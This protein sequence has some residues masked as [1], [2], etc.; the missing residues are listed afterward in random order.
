MRATGGL[1]RFFREYVL[2][3]WKWLAGG[4]LAMAVTNLITLQLPALAKEIV[5]LAV[6]G[7]S[8]SVTGPVEMILLLGG[9]LVFVRFLSRAMFFWPGRK[10]EAAVRSDWFSKVLRLQRSW[11]QKF[12][13]GDL[14]SRLS[15]DTEYLRVLFAFGGMALTNM[16]FLSI[17][18]IYRMQKIDP[19][20][21]LL[22]LTPF[23][24]SVIYFR[25]V[26]PWMHRISKHSQKSL[27]MLTSRVSELFAGLPAVRMAVAEESFLKRTAAVNRR[28][29]RANIRLL[30]L[31][32][33][34][35]PMI[36]FL[37]GLSQVVVL[38]YGG[39]LLVDKQISAGDI[40]LFNSYIIALAFPLAMV[41]ALFAMIERGR[42]ALERLRE[43]LNGPE[44]QPC[45]TGVTR[46]N[47]WS[48]LEIVDLNWQR[49][50][51]ELH[52]I[53]FTL[54]SGEII[55]LCGPVGCGKSTLLDLLIRLESLPSGSVYAL[56]DDGSR[57]DL[58]TV[59]LP[60]LRRRIVYVQQQAMLF[61]N[62]ITN[63]LIFG[64][65]QK[66]HITQP[67]IEK[68][69]A[70]AEFLQD[71]TSFSNGW[72]TVVGERGVRL[73]GGQRQRLA[74]ARALLRSA[75]LYLLDDVLSAVDEPTAAQTMQN[76]K[77]LRKGILLVS[78]RKV[79]LQNCD[80]VIYLDQGRQL[81]CG[82]WDEMLA[83]YPDIERDLHHER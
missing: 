7:K 22:A 42:T 12:V 26:L 20:L 24:F 5:N 13:P 66:R 25:F 9:L 76:L 72:D 51:F 14:L 38:L 56:G 19:L 46:K 73:S 34:V 71:I 6:N 30:Y 60:E 67:E 16:V 39:S 29:Y 74:L 31:E 54:N 4:I 49:P 78:H 64:V 11:F 59:P 21:T 80:R 83:L 50:G 44:E 77:E 28:V 37:A 32:T 55:G 15:N 2:P 45:E 40:L 61:S 3:D 17:F 35:F 53:S 69:A 1:I 79:V 63:N 43:P 65:E 27:A 70:T 48:G 52:N 10:F 75:D 36:S 58:T 18:S 8:K 23:L 68:A 47:R 41:G 57:S 81:G 82:S 62:T 33:V